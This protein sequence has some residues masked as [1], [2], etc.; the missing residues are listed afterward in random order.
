MITRAPLDR[1]SSQEIKDDLTEYVRR[2]REIRGAGEWSR[3]QH[4]DDLTLL[5]DAIDSLMGKLAERG[6]L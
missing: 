5:N 1:R 4:A 6:D 3:L 2:V